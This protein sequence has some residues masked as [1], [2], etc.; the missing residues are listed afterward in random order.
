MLAVPDVA[1]YTFDFSR[2]R[3]ISMNLSVTWST[4]GVPVQL[5]TERGKRK[6]CWLCCPWCLIANQNIV[7]SFWE[8]GAYTMA[9]TDL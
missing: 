4:L 5:G 8:A 1:V 9:H 6:K 3:Q 2:D 7:L